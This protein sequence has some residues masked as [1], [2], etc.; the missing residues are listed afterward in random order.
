L[1]G[2]A[3]SPSHLYKGTPRGGG[4]HTTIPM[5]WN[6]SSP[7]ASTSLSISPS[8]VAP[9][10]LRRSEDYSTVAS[11]CA[12]R[13]LDPIQTDL[14]AQSLLDRSPRRSSSF[15]ICVRVLRGVTLVALKLLYRSHNIRIY[16]TL[17]SA[18][19]ASSSTL[20]REHN[21][22][23]WATRVRYRSFNHYNITSR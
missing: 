12:V 1:R 5:S 17:R 7:C 8:R 19:S 16:T 15:T 13:I 2:K 10:G 14:L 18:T 21:P 9:E 20:V 6:L 23:V 4:E 11:R 22:S 3:A